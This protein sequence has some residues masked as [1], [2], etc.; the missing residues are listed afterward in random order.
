MTWCEQLVSGLEQPINL[1]LLKLLGCPAGPETR[2]QWKRELKTW[3]PRIAA[4]TLKPECPSQKYGNQNKA[5]TKK[6]FF[7]EKKNQKTFAR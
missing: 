1:H 4:I 5:L 7:F 3:L 6:A 2:Q